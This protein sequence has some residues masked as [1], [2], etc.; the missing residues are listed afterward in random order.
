MSQ[1]SRRTHISW[2]QYIQYTYGMHRMPQAQWNYQHFC[3]TLISREYVFTI[4]ILLLCILAFDFSDFFFFLFHFVVVCVCTQ[5][6]SLI[7]DR[8]LYCL[9]CGIGGNTDNFAMMWKTLYSVPISVS[10]YVFVYS[11]RIVCIYTR[12]NMICTYILVHECL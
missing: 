4:R 11:I 3:Y 6:C 10:V 12:Y 9:L 8:L 5:R 2:Y 1:K 7:H